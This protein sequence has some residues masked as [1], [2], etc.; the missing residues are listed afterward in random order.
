MA[1][2]NTNSQ[3]DIRYLTP[4]EIEFKKVKY[5]YFNKHGIKHI[6]YKDVELLKRFL[7]DQ[8]KIIPRRFTGTTLKNQRRLARAIKRARQLALLPYVTDLLKS[9]QH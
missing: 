2:Q 7:N 1:I 9:S 8:G 5:D 6:D 3:D 4:P